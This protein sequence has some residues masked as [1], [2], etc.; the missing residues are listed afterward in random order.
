MSLFVY[1]FCDYAIHCKELDV[2]NKRKVQFYRNESDTGPKKI[3]TWKSGLVTT[4]ALFLVISNGAIRTRQGINSLNQTVFGWLLGIWLG[5]VFA[6]LMRE[7]IYNHIKA[8]VADEEDMRWYGKAPIIGLFM[9]ISLV[10]IGGYGYWASD[11]YSDQSYLYDTPH[12]YYFSLFLSNYN[13]LTGVDSP[14]DE[15]QLK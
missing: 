13:K 11:K 8:L 9:L 1:I 2:K 4:F 15:C 6:F 10:S 5:L 12:T 3:L 7:P 14:W